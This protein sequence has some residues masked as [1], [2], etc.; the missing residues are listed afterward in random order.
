MI[1]EFI[2]NNSMANDKYTPAYPVELAMKSDKILP[3]TCLRVP[4]FG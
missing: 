1:M 3:T 2:L 4:A